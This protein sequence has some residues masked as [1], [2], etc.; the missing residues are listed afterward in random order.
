MVASYEWVTDRF[1]PIVRTRHS[2]R[3]TRPDFRGQLCASVWK[4]KPMVAG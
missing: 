4:R 1:R 3:K 2:V